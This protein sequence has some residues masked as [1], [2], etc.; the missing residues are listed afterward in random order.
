[1]SYYFISL[2][3][4][5]GIA[6]SMDRY[7]LRSC[8]GP[9][10]W[11][12]SD[13]PGV[14]RTIDEKFEHFIE[15]KNLA[16]MPGKPK[17]VKDTYYGFRFLHDI[18]NSRRLTLEYPA[19]KEKYMRRGKRFLSMLEKPCCCIRAVQNAEE[20]AFIASHEDQIKM[21][22]QQYNPNNKV[23]YL[24]PEELKNVPISFSSF[25]YVANYDGN[26]KEA[27][28]RTFESSPALIKWLLDHS[29]PRQ[30]FLNLSQKKNVI[31]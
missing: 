10:D 6:A 17:E 26:S 15:Y 30:R 2:G 3:F 27:L 19:M 21:L 9:F 12:F 14:I 1:M 28:T 24:I 7:G 5:C 4:F 16:A 20:V 8:S 18:E 31:P 11:C 29:D 25:Y 13:F 23:I 22:F